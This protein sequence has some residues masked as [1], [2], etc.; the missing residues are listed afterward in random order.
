MLAQKQSKDS[1]NVI[2]LL[3]TDEAG[4]TRYETSPINA[5][6]TSGDGV[7]S[8]PSVIVPFT[9]TVT[10]TS[11]KAP[12]V[13]VP[14]PYQISVFTNSTYNDSDANTGEAESALMSLHYLAWGR[15]FGD[16]YPPRAY[17]CPRLRSSSE[18]IS[19]NC[20]L[21]TIIWLP[22]PAMP[23]FV[24]SNREVRKVILFHMDELL[25][26]HNAIHAP[27]F[28]QQCEILWAQ[29]CCDHPLWFALYLSILSVSL[30]TWAESLGTADLYLRYKPR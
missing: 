15:S 9:P 23:E 28:L 10:A 1:S 2:A 29:G 16:C 5:L 4:D 30:K 19:I 25:G 22:A 24:L 8:E 26:H 3:E 6:D 11:G 17:P 21:K 7:T 20:N 13:E 12:I 18:M 27:T 14:L